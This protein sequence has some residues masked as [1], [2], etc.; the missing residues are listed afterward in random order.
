MT[1]FYFWVIVDSKIGFIYT[2]N[3][4][5]VRTDT[6]RLMNDKEKLLPKLYVSCDNF[7]V[8]GKTIPISMVAHDKL[9]LVYGR[10]HYVINWY[11]MTNLPH[12]SDFFRS[13]SFSLGITISWT[14]G[15]SFSEDDYF[16]PM[17]IFYIPMFK[18]VFLRK[19]NFACTVLVTCILIFGLYI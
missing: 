3:R 2:L 13:P 12:E 11:S 4:L 9:I 1:M 10:L 19:D 7:S 17:H 8:R 6:G 15:L 16:V 5:T 14:T 18:E